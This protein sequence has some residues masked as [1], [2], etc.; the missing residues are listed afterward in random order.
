[1]PSAA[2]GMAHGGELI[3]Y[4]HLL[5]ISPIGIAVLQYI[6]P[7]T[8]SPLRICVVYIRLKRFTFVFAN[9]YFRDKIGPK[10]PENQNIFMQLYLLQSIIGMRMFIHADFN[11][12]PEEL[13]ET[14]WH[15]ELEM[16][17][18]VPQGPTT[19]GSD[20]K[21]TFVL[22]H[23]DSFPMFSAFTFEHNMP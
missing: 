1:M 15:N 3:A 7:K 2:G 11:C 6:Q 12:T 23:A 16:Q 14:E 17:V 9:A 13:V 10:H 19:Q 22:L 5:N 4:I 21:I 20:R 8:G 18:L